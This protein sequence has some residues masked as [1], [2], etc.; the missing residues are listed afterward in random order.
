MLNIQSYILSIIFKNQ[1]DMDDMADLSD[2]RNEVMDRV[3]MVMDKAGEYR[4]RYCACDAIANISKT[5]S[6]L[7]LW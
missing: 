6:V 5:K 1:A 7:Q 2:M 3:Q 4:N